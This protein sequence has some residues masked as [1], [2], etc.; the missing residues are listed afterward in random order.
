MA[1]QNDHESG[2]S[3]IYTLADTGRKVKLSLTV[4]NIESERI[5]E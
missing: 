3:G 5:G 1:A 4:E 2:L